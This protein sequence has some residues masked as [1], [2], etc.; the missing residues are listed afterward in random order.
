MPPAVP[1]SRYNFDFNGEGRF[2]KERLEQMWVTAYTDASVRYEKAGW[3]VWLRSQRGRVIRNGECPPEIRDSNMAELYAALQAVELAKETWPET[4][5]VLLNMDS[6][7]VIDKITGRV[8]E[9]GKLLPLLR[10]L[11]SHGLK[12]RCRHIRGHRAASGESTP[13]YL[14]DQVDK[15]AGKVTGKYR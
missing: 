2:S 15:V 10:R 3:S 1:R 8:D 4:S 11:H 5:A 14:N 7:G 6:T 9:N 13:S 12:I